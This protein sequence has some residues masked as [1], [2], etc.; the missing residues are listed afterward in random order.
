MNYIMYFKFNYWFW[1]F[2]YFKFECF[3]FHFPKSHDIITIDDGTE[4]IYNQ[5]G[6]I[7]PTHIRSSNSDMTIHFTSGDI[8]ENATGEDKGFE[9]EIEYILSGN[10][11]VQVKWMTIS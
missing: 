10:A 3:V 8:W 5:T 9:I 4:N 7:L 1:W 11:E 2:D 6:E